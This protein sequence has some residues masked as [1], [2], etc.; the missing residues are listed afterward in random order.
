[1]RKVLDLL[2][3]LRLTLA[4][5]LAL[6]AFFLLGLVVPQKQ[7]LQRELYRQWQRERPALVSAL[8]ALGLTDIHRSPA[9]AVLWGAFFVNLGVVMVRRV[10]GTLR[11]TRIDG[12]IPAPA[13]GAGA[14][15]R[16]A[17]PVERAELGPVRSFFEERRFA[18]HVD[19]ARLRAVKHRWGPLATPA[20]HLSFFL[21]AAGAGV[22]TATRFEG[23]VDLGEGEVF[24]GALAQYASPPLLPRLGEPPRVRFIVEAIRPE[25]VG[26]LATAVR[27]HLRDAQG[28]LRTSEVNYPYEEGGASFVVKNLGVA[29]LLVLLGPGE[30][31]RF[32]GLI[33][34]NVLNGRSDSF[35]LEDVSFRA[36][37]FPDYYRDGG[38][39]GTRSQEM[40]DPVLRLTASTARG[41]ETAASLRPGEV[42]QIGPYQLAFADWR[43]WVRFYVRAERGL[44]LL[45]LGFALGAAALGWRLFLY[46]REYVAEVVPAG[47]GGTLHVA[48]RSEFYRALFADEA[49]ALLRELERSVAAP[50]AAA[51]A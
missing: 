47:A 10:P 39:E 35:K 49:D 9:A 43:Y 48:G 6:A 51:D 30:Q 2:S 17:L 31:E 18:V 32:A 11:R 23:H 3:S 38:G 25:I 19:G 44:W 24:T 42:M 26:T 46:R 5:L 40:R 22:S 12:T 20:F 21:V 1:M 37:F 15:V 27:V 16:W 33:R 29:P 14:P 8:E 34:L 45:W 4:L 13:G 36:E 28:I 41:G 50:R 7:V